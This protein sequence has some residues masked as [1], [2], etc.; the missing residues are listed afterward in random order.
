MTSMMRRK[1]MMATVA[2]FRKR[3][4]ELIL[5]RGALGVRSRESKT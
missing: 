5:E 3:S 1:M 4:K 2:S